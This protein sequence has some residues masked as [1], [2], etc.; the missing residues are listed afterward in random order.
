MTG[1]I[2]YTKGA[3]NSVLSG[4]I[5]G[6]VEAARLTAGSGNTNFGALDNST[7]GSKRIFIRSPFAE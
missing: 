1:T 6:M 4:D 2:D 3:Q 5:S 7:R